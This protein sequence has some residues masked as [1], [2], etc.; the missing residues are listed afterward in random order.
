[1]DGWMEDAVLRINRTHQFFFLVP[2]ATLCVLCKLASGSLSSYF[3]QQEADCRSL[4]ICSSGQ[5][6]VVAFSPFFP[7]NKNQYPKDDR[8]SRKNP[9]SPERNR[10]AEGEDKEPKRG[11]E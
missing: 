11:D 3:S 2:L 5:L 1:M 7:T 9:S 4:P 10:G 6:I 8:C